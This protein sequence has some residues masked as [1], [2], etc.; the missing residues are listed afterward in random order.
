M[1]FTIEAHEI[2][3][4][5]N[6]ALAR[7]FARTVSNRKAITARGWYPLN[8]ALLLDTGLRATMTE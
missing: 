1:Q 6:Y 5:V 7:S 2:I 4:I 3:N 8:R